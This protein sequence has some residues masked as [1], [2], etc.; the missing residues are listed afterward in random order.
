MDKFTA[1][2]LLVLVNDKIA[3]DALETYTKYRIEMHR[4]HLESVKNM[5]KILEI[6]GA[7]DELR[8]FKTLRDEVI[9]ASKR[10]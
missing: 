10:D 1:Q 2:K 8:R 7:I 9:Q 4:N 5:E 6:Q 3:M